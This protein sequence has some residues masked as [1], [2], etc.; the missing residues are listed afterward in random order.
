MFCGKSL[1]V[2]G[3]RATFAVAFRK[4]GRPAEAGASPPGG[5][6]PPGR[7]PDGRA[8]RPGLKKVQ[9]FPRKILW[10]RKMVVT[11]QSF[12][13]ADAPRDAQGH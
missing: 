1:A 11:L 13:G 9:N 12:S 10:V 4:E 6:A 7:R 5:A 2:R 3:R 8:Q